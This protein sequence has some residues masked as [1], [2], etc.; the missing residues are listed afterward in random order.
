MCR[1]GAALPHTFNCQKSTLSENEHVCNQTEYYIISQGLLYA[2][3]TLFSEKCEE[4]DKTGN[5]K[6]Q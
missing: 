5:D 6:K 3:E 2:A 1:F 4:Y